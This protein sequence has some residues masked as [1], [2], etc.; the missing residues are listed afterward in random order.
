MKHPPKK[1]RE[2]IEKTMKTLEIRSS[3]G[4]YVGHY[5]GF[6][7]EYSYELAWIVYN[8]EHNIKFSRCQESFEYFDSKRGKWRLYFPDFILP[9]GTIVEI[10]GYYT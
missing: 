5:H 1:S 6:Y 2:T 7:F 3:R 10:K 8:I 4:D 9:D